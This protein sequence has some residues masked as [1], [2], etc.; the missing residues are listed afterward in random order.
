MIR[1]VAGEIDRCDFLHG[2]SYDVDAPYGR[3]AA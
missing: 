1:R 2:Y 3:T